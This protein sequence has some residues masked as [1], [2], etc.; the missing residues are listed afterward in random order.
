[1][2]GE[3]DGDGA[4]AWLRSF[5]ASFRAQRVELDELDRRS[6]DGDFGTNLLPAIERVDS[7]PAEPAD[8]GEAFA[9]LAAAFMNAGGTSG[10]LF[11]VWFR[12]IGRAAA[13]AGRLD[14]TA[15]ADGAQRGLDAVTKLGGAQPG[16]KTM[17]DAMAPA[18]AA[19]AAAVGSGDGLAA[20]LEAAASAAR[21]G[22]EATA[23]LVAR[24]GRA[25]Y[26]GE[27][28]R[29]VRDPGAV[30]VALFFEAG[31]DALADGEARD[32]HV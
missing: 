4:R 30:A 20:A 5:A 16:D 2:C 14:A 11:G 6:G 31:S 18:T 22:A 29:G 24:R 19:L 28:S 25:S 10:P 13:A 27:V 12:S 23:G 32:D 8:A 1:V 21:K 26:V 17:V 15:L 3:L 9:A 7:E